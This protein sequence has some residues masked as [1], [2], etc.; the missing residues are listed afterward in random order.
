MELNVANGVI[1]RLVQYLYPLELECDSTKESP[2]AKS[3][4]PEAP[5]F[6]PK[7]DA[8]EAARMRIKQTQMM[9][10]NV[11]FNSEKLEH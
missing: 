8:A 7:R 2:K 6:R 9:D 5:Q 4:R 11:S 1:E 10:E 3:L